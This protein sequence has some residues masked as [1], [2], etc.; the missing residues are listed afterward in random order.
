[1]KFF[2]QL[3]IS[4][5]KNHDFIWFH[6]KL[7]ML[8][9]VLSDITSLNRTTKC[10]FFLKS[11]GSVRRERLSCKHKHTGIR[12]M[13]RETEYKIRVDSKDS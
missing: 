2:L 11:R 1:M 8:S 10:L 9:H 3:F 13:R 7:L 6:P 5:I 4:E 12:W